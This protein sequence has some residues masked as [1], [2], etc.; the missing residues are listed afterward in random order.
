MQLV[1]NAEEG[2]IAREGGAA[3]PARCCSA[4][5]FHK[6][7]EERT[8]AEQEERYSQ[9]DICYACLPGPGPYWMCPR[10]QEWY[11]YRTPRVWCTLCISFHCLRCYVCRR[12]GNQF[13][14]LHVEDDHFLG[15]RTNAEQEERHSQSDICYACYVPYE[16]VFLI[17]AEPDNMTVVYAIYYHIHLILLL[18]IVFLAAWW[19]WKMVSAPKPPP[20]RWITYGKSKDRFLRRAEAALYER[21]K[22]SVTM[23]LTAS[24]AALILVCALA[25]YLDSDD[26]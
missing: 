23:I 19:L 21:P 2:D 13:Q 10:C 16:H 3:Q 8:N 15:E 17:L 11:P 6:L 26:S 4:L 22:I 20:A 12:R 1:G 7:L 24:L 9:Y 18:T 25:P 5:S 14:S